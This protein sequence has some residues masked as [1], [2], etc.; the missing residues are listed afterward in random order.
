MSD[1]RGDRF[2][3]DA[4]PLSERL[5]SA[6]RSGP[7]SPA[8]ALQP[9]P[10]PPPPKRSRAVR[11]PL[12]VFLNFVLTVVIVAVVVLAGAALIGRSQFNEPGALAQERTIS[13]DRGVGLRDIADRL[14]ADGAIS[15]KW[16]FVA[17]VWL[18][19]EQN[20]LKAGEYLIPANASMANIMNIMVEGRSKYYAVTIP[21]GRTSRQIV[22]IL[23]ADP[24][25]VGEITEIP[26]EGSLLPETY[27][28]TR[29]D[30]RQ[31]VIARMQRERDRIL[32]DAWAR[33]ASDVP[34]SSA[35][36]LAILASIVE[37]ETALADERSRVAAVFI[38]RLRL[39]MRL[40]SDPTVIYGVF[41]GEGHPP[42]YR[43]TRAHLDQ[44]TP[45]NT[46]VIDGLPPAPIANAGAASLEAVA[47]PS[48]TRDLFF[49]A[50]G[51]GGH[52]FAETYEEHLRNVARWREI[53]AAQP[54][55]EPAAAPAEEAPAAGDE[56]L[57]LTP[58]E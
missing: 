58:T 35:E 8:E 46:Y 29:G 19:G 27:Q 41:G 4:D 43:L 3:D 51:T 5:V 38:N 11:H 22:D 40:Q 23:N 31:N 28:F 16:L 6:A 25:L 54:A 21:E 50:D 2:D 34:L 17:G 56:P 42:E 14:H 49:V 7:R 13:V 57:A 37:K 39:N 9:E 55:A 47:N 26:P 32:T 18:S 45:Y 24:I 12:V 33:R 53:E 10:V 15:S 44:P 52:A 36:E 48:R 1:Y 30:T 20:S